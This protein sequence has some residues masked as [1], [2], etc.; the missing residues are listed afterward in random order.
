M[1]D[2]CE[3]GQIVIDGQTYRSDVIIFP[4]RVEASWWRAKGHELAVADLRDVLRDPPE[5]LIVGT[6][7]YGRMVV[8]PET[9]QTLASRGVELIAQATEPACKTYNEMAAAGR[10]V[11][12]ALHLT[13]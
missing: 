4:H 3:F 2:R 12:A 13:C 8:L 7:R 9:E 5:V 6:G 10:R 1:I 11:V